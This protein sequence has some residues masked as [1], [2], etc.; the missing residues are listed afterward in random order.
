MNLSV[1]ARR[2]ALVALVAACATPAACADATPDEADTPDLSSGEDAGGEAATGLPGRP[3]ASGLEDVIDASNG[4]S[5][6]EDGGDGGATKPCTVHGWCHTDVPENETLRGVW[7][8]GTGVVWTVSEEGDILRWDGTAWSTVYTG[9]GKLFTIWGSGPTD[10]WVGGTNGLFHGTGATSATLS[11][12]PVAVEGNVPILSVWG[13]SASDV[14]AVGNDGSTS[15]VL[16]YGGPPVDASTSGWVTDPV[17]TR[18]TGKLAKVYG[19]SPTD[20]WIIGTML[21]GRNTKPLIWH[22]SPDDAGTPVFA[23]DTSFAY[24]ANNAVAGGYTADTNNVLYFGKYPTLPYALWGRRA[25]GTK[26]YTWKDA[27][28]YSIPHPASCASEAH[29]GVIGFGV[30]DV[31]LYGDWGRLCHFDGTSWE[32]AAVSIEDVPLTNPFWDAWAPAGDPTQMWVVGK[33]VALRKQT[34]SNP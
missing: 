23:Q 17:G 15:L 21:S 13:S 5:T 4:D 16:H 33:G 25:D 32:L 26:A 11:W 27:F 24:Y 29:N 8:D 9:A 30:N 12:T 28:H 14:W 10:I 2:T 22:L 18:I 1:N 6:H 20:V 31:W 3:D 7:G 34:T 19:Y